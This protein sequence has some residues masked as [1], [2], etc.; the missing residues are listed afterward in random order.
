MRVNQ[1]KVAE[2][3]AGQLTERLQGCKTRGMQLGCVRVGG[4]DPRSGWRVVV[5]YEDF[6]H[7]IPGDTYYYDS[8]GNAAMA[9]RMALRS[10]AIARGDD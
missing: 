2:M 5:E 7:C 4:A 8:Y 3:Y 6:G 1:K 10:M 9:M